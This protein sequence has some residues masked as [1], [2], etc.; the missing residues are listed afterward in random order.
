MVPLECQYHK[1]ANIAVS[2]LPSISVQ[3][4]QRAGRSGKP[5]FGALQGLLSLFSD[6]EAPRPRKTTKNVKA[7]TGRYESIVLARLRRDQLSTR[8]PR[9]DQSVV[10][11]PADLHL[12]LQRGGSHVCVQPAAPLP[13]TSRCRLRIPGLNTGSAFFSPLDQDLCATPPE[14]GI[15]LFLGETQFAIRTRTM[16]TVPTGRKTTAKESVPHLEKRAELLRAHPSAEPPTPTPCISDLL[17]PRQNFLLSLHM[18]FSHSSETRKF[19]QWNVAHRSSASGQR[20]YT[21][22]LGSLLRAAAPDPSIAVLT[23]NR[24]HTRRRV[25]GFCLWDQQSPWRNASLRDAPSFSRP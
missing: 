16:I 10:P 12:R 6:D 19:L 22:C 17:Q 23:A 18:C 20:H 25:P 14:L 24:S 5:V 4:I 11:C 8:S 9:P 3:A 21:Y 7:R 2:G 13:L 1:A 15:P